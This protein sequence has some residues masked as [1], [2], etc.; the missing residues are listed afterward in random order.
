M[1]VFRRIILNR[2]AL[3]CV[4]E[5]HTATRSC[6][7]HHSDFMSSGPDSFT[8]A[9][10]SLGDRC[11]EV[12]LQVPLPPAVQNS[13]CVWCEVCLC[14]T[15]ERDI[16]NMLGSFFR[17]G[18]WGDTPSFIWEV[19]KGTR[20][21]PATDGRIEESKV[22]TREREKLRTTESYRQREMELERDKKEVERQRQVDR[23]LEN[24]LYSSQI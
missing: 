16:E 2:H 4:F 1:C 6:I 8:S 18:N 11:C 7:I 21:F 12:D 22:Q 14:R 19:R 17:R 15:W 23:H 24:V 10:A 20:L 5:T 13:L 3:E 9:T